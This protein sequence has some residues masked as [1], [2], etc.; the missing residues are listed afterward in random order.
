[1]EVR[2]ADSQVVALT[3]EAGCCSSDATDEQGR[4]LRGSETHG[5]DLLQNSF[6]IGK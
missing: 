6:D 3:G 4:D 1:M 2:Q 5:A